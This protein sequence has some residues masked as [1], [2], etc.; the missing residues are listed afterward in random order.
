MSW[1]TRSISERTIGRIQARGH[2]V[3]WLV[4]GRGER[5][6]RTATATQGAVQPLDI[7]RLHQSLVVVFPELDPGAAKAVATVYEMLGEDG[8]LSIAVLRHVVAG[9]TQS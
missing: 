7:K 9:F 5:K 3:E 6:T 4:K 1:L 2:S 8:T